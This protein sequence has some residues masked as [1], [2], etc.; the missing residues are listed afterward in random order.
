MVAGLELAD[1]LGPN[2]PFE[3]FSFRVLEGS[4]PSRLDLAIVHAVCAKLLV[5]EDG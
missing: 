2:I 4:E 1:F 5:S 3:R